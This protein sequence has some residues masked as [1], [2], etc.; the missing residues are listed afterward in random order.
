[1][2]GGV[3]RKP[4]DAAQKQR[5]S[6]NTK[7]RVALALLE[8]GKKKGMFS[9]EQEKGKITTIQRYVGNPVDRSALGIDNSDPDELY[10]TSSP[11]D[12]ELLIGNFFQDLLSENPKI[13]SRANKNEI[14][15]YAHELTSM[16]G[17]SRRRS[18]PTPILDDESNG[19]KP[20]KT[21]PGKNTKPARLP[22][23]TELSTRLKALRSWKLEH[24]YNSICNVSLQ[25][26][27]PLLAV[28]VCLSS[29]V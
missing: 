10:R 20:R 12:V 1:M 28:G 7:N 19:K 11:E 25:E 21:R 26:N 3:G 13:T 18:D 22:F 16:A 17:Q 27:T 14:E 6:G 29:S 15:K 9:A 4:W 24:L 2:Q 5:H 8:Y 23:N